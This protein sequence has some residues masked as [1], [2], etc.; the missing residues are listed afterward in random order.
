MYMCMDMYIH[1]CSHPQLYMFTLVHIY[2]SPTIHT[3]VCMNIYIYIYTHVR[4]YACA[5]AICV[6]THTN[7]SQVL[8]PKPIEGMVPFRR[9]Q[10]P[11]FLTRPHLSPLIA[12][13][14]GGAYVRY[15]QYQ[16]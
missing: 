9:Q 14:A 16:G 7:Y 4:V 12:R 2:T 11:V 10:P 6:F 8:V 5:Y 3:C 1:M 13:G 15:H